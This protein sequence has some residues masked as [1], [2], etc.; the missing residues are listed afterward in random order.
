MV[1]NGASHLF[2]GSSSCSSLQD[3]SS[4]CSTVDFSTDSSHL[5]MDRAGE[6]MVSTLGTSHPWYPV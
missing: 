5:R 3:S 2:S 4:D 1:G 6:G